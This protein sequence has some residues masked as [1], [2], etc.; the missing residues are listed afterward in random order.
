MLQIRRATDAARWADFEAMR[1]GAPGRAR[2]VARFVPSG[3]RVLD[4]GAG[5]MA[6]RNELQPASDYTPADLLAWDRATQVVDLNQGQFPTGEFDITIASA[7][8]EFLH[9]PPTLLRRLCAAAPRLVLTYP[10]VEVQPNRRREFG[11]FNDYTSRVLAAHTE[12]AGWRLD[13]R[14]EN[15]NGVVFSLRRA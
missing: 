9:D 2:D 12:A 7:V 3:A 1:D 5:T 15:A 14:I 11:Y 10:T 13:D 8:L 4:L 6:L